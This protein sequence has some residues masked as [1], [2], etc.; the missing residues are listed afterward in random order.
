MRYALRGYQQE[1]VDAVI[2]WIKQSTSSCLIVLPTGAGKSLVIAEIARI[3]NSMSGKKILCLAPT[4]E[5]V[6]QNRAKY[7][8]TGEP[9]SMFSSSAGKKELKHPVVFGSPGTVKGSVEKFK[10][11]SAIIIDEA[12]GITPSVKYIIEEIT[13]LNPL[14]RIIALTATPHRMGTGYIFKTHYEDGPTDEETA[15]D[16]YYDTVVYELPAERLINEGFLTPP[17]TESTE[18]H[19]DTASLEI[20]RLG[21][22]T[23]ASLERAFNGRGRLTSSII[24]DVISRSRNRRGVMIFAATKA[25]AEEIMESLPP[26]MSGFIHGGLSK[27]ERNKILNDFKIERIKYIVNQ[28]ILTVGVDVPHA[29]H[30]VLMRATESPRLLQQIIG[31]GTRLCDGKTDFLVSDYAGNID[32]HFPDGDLF[33]PEIKAM[34]KKESTPYSVCCPSCRMD[35][36]FS[37]RPNPDGLE[38]DS[39]GYFLDLAGDRLMIDV[40]K[41]H[42]DGNIEYVKKPVPAHFGRQCKN[43]ILNRVSHKVERC[44]FKWSFKECP[45]CQHENDI[46]ARY[47]TACKAEIVDP[48]TKLKEEAAKLDN[49]PYA[50][51]SAEVIHMGI[52]RHLGVDGKPDTIKVDY[53]IEEKPF[54]VSEWYSP[55]SENAWLM[56]RFHEFSDNAFGERLEMNEILDRRNEGIKP[57]M[58]MFRRSKGN[59]Y[60]KVTGVYWGE[61]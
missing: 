24:E 7:L 16:P 3:I 40:L 50:T 54:M 30:I 52:T 4:S 33:K 43:F 1:A 19:Y 14:I 22:F 21:R 18:F 60:S 11:Y 49:D 15:I 31:R 58:V 28:N 25:H 12:D 5:L 37:S 26:E 27:K 55:M 2:A 20:D 32:K 13:K 51:K 61:L 35:N 59:K 34:R 17:V 39:E 36:E 56:K 57:T 44:T 48:N 41:K 45:E 8:L 38:S 42:S 29:D 23:S 46:A 47:C 53:A 6:T 9:A 10:N